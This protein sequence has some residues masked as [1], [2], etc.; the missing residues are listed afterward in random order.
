MFTSQKNG[1][2]AKIRERGFEPTDFIP[3]EIKDSFT[4]NFKDSPLWFSVKPAGMRIAFTYKQFVPGYIAVGGEATDIGEIYG[5]FSEWLATHVKGYLEE[6]A[7]PDLWGQ[8]NEE[9][10]VISE[11]MFSGAES[12]SFSEE[13]KAQIKLSLGQFQLLIKE[14][15]NPSSDQI[16]VIE[17]RLS[18]LAE[19]VDRLN[20]FDWKSILASSII[21]IA[22]ALSLNTE[23]G[24]ALFHLAKQAFTHI[25]YLP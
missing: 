18:Y 9:R 7:I 3:R 24:K 6:E 14:A 5:I 10:A 2:L 11:G 25:V 1:F 4:L 16:V 12:E 8:L 20:K 22:T 17:E 23:Q 21:N 13:E 19:G 15:F